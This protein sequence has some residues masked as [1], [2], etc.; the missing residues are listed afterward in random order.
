M[1]RKPKKPAPVHF[2]NLQATVVRPPG[3]TSPHWY[4]RIR[5]AGTKQDVWTGRASRDAIGTM[6]RDLV[7]RGVNEAKDTGASPCETVDDLLD[8]YLGHLQGLP[9]MNESTLKLYRSMK[10]A[11]KAVVGD[12]LVERWDYA[13]QADYL[14]RRQVASRTHYMELDLIKRAW[15]W[16]LRVGLLPK[17]SV[18]WLRV[19]VAPSKDKFTPTA[20][21]IGKVVDNARAGSACS[22]SSPGGPGLGRTRSRP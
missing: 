9:T 21:Q 1:A 20:E 6:M 2:A 13:A 8:Y 19:E 17:R 11:L 7:K 15:T 12:I 18:D 14:T 5:V 3:K 22:C 4:W 10:R 16:G